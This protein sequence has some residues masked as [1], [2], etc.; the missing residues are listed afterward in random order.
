MRVKMQTQERIDYE[1]F[2]D[3]FARRY[4]EELKHVGLVPE[5]E[6]HWLYSEFKSSGK[7]PEKWLEQQELS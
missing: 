3:A 1:R 7:T 5:T 6:V 4:R 2:I